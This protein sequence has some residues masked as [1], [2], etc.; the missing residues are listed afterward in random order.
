MAFHPLLIAPALLLFARARPQIKSLDA[1]NLVI[2]HVQ[3]NRAPQMRR[4]T[5]RAHGRINGESVFHG[6]A[7]VWAALSFRLSLLA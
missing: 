5:Y 4:R 2:S 3:A 7:V 6:V 1:K